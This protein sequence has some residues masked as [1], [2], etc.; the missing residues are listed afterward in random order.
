M[1]NLRKTGYAAMALL[2]VFVAGGCGMGRSTIPGTMTGSTGNAMIGTGT[3]IVPGTSAITGINN[4]VIGRRNPGVNTGTTSGMNLGTNYRTNT[5]TNLS[6]SLGTNLGSLT[7]PGT[8]VGTNTSTS[9]GTGFVPKGF[10]TAGNKG[11]K[12]GSYTMSANTASGSDKATVTILKGKI[13]KVDLRSYDKAGNEVNYN[14]IT[15]NRTSKKTSQNLNSIRNDI[16]RQVI[17]RQDSNV[18]MNKNNAAKATTDA[19]ISA[20]RKALDKAKA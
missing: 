2:L 17:S 4:S 12:D 20:V 7:N 6:K 3:A 11:Y 18:T 13:K 14:T 8:K 10:A 16:Q 9:P 15:G 1:K 19:W 5:G